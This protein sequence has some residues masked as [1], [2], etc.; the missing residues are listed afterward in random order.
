MA[1][2]DLEGKRTGRPRGAKTTAKRDILWTYCN[3]GKVDA[4]PP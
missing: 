2:K 3:L 1:L 4:K